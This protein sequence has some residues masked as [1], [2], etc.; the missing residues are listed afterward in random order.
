MYWI[1]DLTMCWAGWENEAT[2]RTPGIL[3]SFENKVPLVGVYCRNDNI[4]T[5]PKR[6]TAH[7]SAD[8]GYFLLG[9]G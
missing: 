9:E 7:H 8:G 2:Q 4:N 6:G 5:L 1:A 3:S